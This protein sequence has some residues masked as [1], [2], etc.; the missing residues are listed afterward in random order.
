[1]SNTLTARVTWA[2]TATVAL[3]VGLM[4]VLAF[5]IMYEQ[6]DDLA[7][8]LVS[9]QSDL[10]GGRII[11]GYYGRNALAIGYVKDRPAAADF[12]RAFT[13]ATIKSGLVTRSIAKAG[14]HG[15]VAG[16]M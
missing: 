1:M 8:Q 10:P 16:G 5:S 2:I 6:E 14:V 13:A 4:A 9:H 3:F 7:D 15:A 11:P 12:V